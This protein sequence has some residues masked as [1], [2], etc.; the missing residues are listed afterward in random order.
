MATARIPLV[1]TLNQR[2]LEGNATLTLNEDQRF[3]NCA[4]DVV[5]NPVLG[6]TTVYI[7]KRQ[8]WG[9]DSVI[10]PGDASTGLI[11]PQS[12]NVTLSA[13]GETN[14]TIYFGTTSVGVITGRAL[15]FTET[16]I[17]AV[18]HVMIRSSD[19]T[20]W[21]YVDGA[22][23]V[24]TYSVTTHTNTI[25][26]G[27]AS[28]AGMYS[29]QE[30]SG[31]GIVAGTKISSVTSSVAIV[32][33]TATTGTATVTLTKT[34]IAK[35]ISA[36]F[37]ATGTF[38]S[39]FV[40]MDGFLFYSTDDGNLRNSDI[41]SVTAYT[42]TAVVAPNMAPDPP[43][44]VARH[45]NMVIVLGSSS[46]E[47]FYNQGSYP[48]PLLRSPQFFDRIGVLDQRS[49]TT[50]ENDIYFVSSPT[51]G[52]IG[53]YRIR[54]MES[55][56]V[57]TPVI[58]RILGSIS[59]TGVVYASSFRLAGYQYAAFSMSLATDTAGDILLLESGDN[60]LLETADSML[61]ETT[62]GQTAAF[63]RMM[64]Y[65][66]GL[67]IW[68]EWD[69]VEATFIVGI[70]STSSNQILATSR[71]VTDGKIYTINPVANG[72]LYQDDGSAF[73]TEIRTAR[74]DHGTS[75]R[76]YVTEIRLVCD[77]QSSGTVTLEKND[78]DFASADWVTLGTFDLTSMSPVITR[79]GSYLSGRA[80]R[81]THSANSPFR[82]EA[83]EIVY[84]IG[85]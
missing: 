61:T 11:K 80:Y 65:N 56:R 25:V 83:L 26:D 4:F 9:V 79:C 60:I 20:G 42:S 19:G 33:D 8:G 81:L 22:K 17:S 18:A 34:P 35:I 36:N 1:G 46:K 40:E 21:Y 53:I 15:H 3:L 64:V 51:A 85:T 74:I 70:G 27:I 57:S 10:A 59:A 55:V 75:K 52:D 7:S 72:E 82:A 2:G 84:T 13:F 44:A 62:T 12:F 23:D 73:T 58:D 54:G 66:A 16:L 45:K 67:N 48:S 29:G 43:R 71:L 69:S 63:A 76:K 50:I 39:A 30:V 24:L 28:T 47:V 41:N 14:S 32:L 38:I 49:V 5:Q 6:K 68:S 77:R 37:V 31:T 78:N